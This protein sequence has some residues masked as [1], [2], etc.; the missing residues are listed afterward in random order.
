MTSENSRSLRLFLW[1]GAIFFALTLMSPA[2]RFNV[3]L[4]NMALAALSA[5][6]TIESIYPQ[7]HFLTPIF[8]V[9]LFLLFIIIY[10]PQRLP[11]MIKVTL[12]VS[13]LFALG[14]SFFLRT[15]SQA[16][17]ESMAPLTQHTW[18]YASFHIL[19]KLWSPWFVVLLFWVYANQTITTN[20]AKWMYPGWGIIYLTSPFMGTT[21]SFVID[22]I[23]TMINVPVTFALLTCAVFATVWFSLKRIKALAI[24]VP[25]PQTN[26]VQFTFG[27][28]LKYLVIILGIVVCFGLCTEI[29]SLSF[30]HIFHT[31]YSKSTDLGNKMIV[32]AQIVSIGSVILL[33][34]TCWWVWFMGW[35]RS[36]LA[37]PSLAL[38]SGG[39]FFAVTLLGYGP[40]TNIWYAT[41]CQ[42][43]FAGVGWTLFLTTKE[44]AYIPLNPTTKAKGKAVIDFLIGGRIQSYLIVLAL[45][46]TASPSIEANIPY[47]VVME[48]N[49]SYLAVIYV[50]AI[51]VWFFCLFKLKGYYHQALIANEGNV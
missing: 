37:V 8:K 15:L 22:W 28:R 51:V 46:W 18:V 48:A 2:L 36:A 27:F 12:A 50:G 42:I 35:F 38:V 33:F 31:T 21:A 17:V 9:F 26:A 41:L 30:K 20:Q 40:T 25:T 13:L 47:L 49:I 10:K 5:I 14:H 16:G 32:H 6:P 4:Q 19:E 45:T 34:T 44:I 1:F 23:D 11:A 43:I 24:Q 3:M 39:I 7:L 29:I